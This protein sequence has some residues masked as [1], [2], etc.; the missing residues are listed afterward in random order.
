MKGLVRIAYWVASVAAAPAVFASV[1]TYEG[2]TVGSPIQGQDNWKFGGGAATQQVAFGTGYDTTTVAKDIA[3]TADIASR[4]NDGNFSIPNFMATDLAVFQF[5][6][7]RVGSSGMVLLGPGYDANSNGTIAF[8]GSENP[9]W[10]G[11]SAG[12]FRVYNGNDGYDRTTAI[13]GTFAATDWVTYRLEV[14]LSANGGDGAYWFSYKN[15][16]DGETSFTPVAGVDFQNANLGLLGA[17]RP[18]PSQWNGMITDI[19]L[20]ASADNLTFSLVVPEPSTMLLL[21]LGGS[22]IWR[23]RSRRH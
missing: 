23:A 10:F 15:L 6:G 17:G 21:A 4:K 8:A 11:F 13:P 3:N 1:Y 5:D 18:Q 7:Q 2:L 16:T 14:D 20:Q 9:F 19:R 12:S 22:L